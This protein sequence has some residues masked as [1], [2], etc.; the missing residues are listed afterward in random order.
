MR[1]ARMQFGLNTVL[2]LVFLVSVVLATWR[3]E[4]TYGPLTATVGGATLGG[5]VGMRRS[6]AWAFVG[7]VAG[8]LLGCCAYL[9]FVIIVEWP[10]IPSQGEA[11]RLSAVGE[12]RSPPS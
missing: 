2:A 7:I 1:K 4:T 8:A 9:L 11:D 10:P 3:F 6:A 5:L 12:H